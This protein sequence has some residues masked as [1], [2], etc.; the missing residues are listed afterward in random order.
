[1]SI[2]MNDLFTA[3]VLACGSPPDDMDLRAMTRY[4][5][6]LIDFWKTQIRSTPLVRWQLG[7]YERKEMLEAFFVWHQVERLLAT[8]QR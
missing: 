2:S 5:L 1:M 8:V 4:Q 3:S 6:S 7:P